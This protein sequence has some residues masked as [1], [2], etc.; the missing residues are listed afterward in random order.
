[1]A[2]MYAVY[3]GPDG[4]AGIARRTHRYAAVLA[5]GLRAAGVEIVHDGFF[6]TLTVRV[7]GRAAEVVA[8]ARAVGVNLRPIDADHVGIAC[9][10]T[11]NRAQRRRRARRLRRHRRPRRARRGHRRRAARPGCCAPSPT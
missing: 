8:A 11:T 1:M 7:P 6:D 4:L 2:G 9:D 5:A 10:E 3:H